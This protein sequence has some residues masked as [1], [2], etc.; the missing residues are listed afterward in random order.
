MKSLLHSQHPYFS[1]L[2]CKFFL[3]LCHV[4]NFQ[5]G[6]V[7]IS[8]KNLYEFCIERVTVGTNNNKTTKLGKLLIIII[9]NGLKDIKILH[10]F[11]LRNIG[12]T[13]Y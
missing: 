5:S 3:N 4:L 7:F 12:H 13:F 6:H 9:V 8:A 11:L 10:I 2:H 1:C